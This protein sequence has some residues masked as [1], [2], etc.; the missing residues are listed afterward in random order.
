MEELARNSIAQQQEEG[1]RQREGQGA[2]ERAEEESSESRN[3]SARSPGASSKRHR[4]TEHLAHLRAQVPDLPRCRIRELGRLQTTRR[5]HGGAALSRHRFA[6]AAGTF[7][8]HAASHSPLQGLSS[9]AA[10]ASLGTR[11]WAGV[12]DGDEDSSWGVPRQSRN[13]ACGPTRR[14]GYSLH[15]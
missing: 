8:A 4:P 11:P 15:R 2:G 10:S 5:P 9:R 7:F 3:A 12:G 1:C 14:S 6:A 13:T